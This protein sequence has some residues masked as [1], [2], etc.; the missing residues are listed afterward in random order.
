MGGPFDP[1]GIREL[2]VTLFRL[3]IFGA[4]QTG[5]EGVQRTTT[6]TFFCN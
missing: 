1:L 6:S 4:P 5:G 3:G 2:H